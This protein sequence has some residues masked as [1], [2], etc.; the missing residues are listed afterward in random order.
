MES[1]RITQPAPIYRGSKNTELFNRAT[2]WL[3]ILFVFH[4]FLHFC[5]LTDNFD[6]LQILS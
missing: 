2:P 1:H 6:F 3:I 4:C 5:K